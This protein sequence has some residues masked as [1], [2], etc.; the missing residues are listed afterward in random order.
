MAERGLGVDHSTIGRW[1]LRYAPQLNKRIPVAQLCYDVEVARRKLTNK[2]SE[3]AATSRLYSEEEPSWAEDAACVRE[4]TFRGRSWQGIVDDL[5]ADTSALEGAGIP[6]YLQ[7][8]LGPDYLDSQRRLFRLIVHSSVRE[9]AERVLRQEVDAV[10]AGA[11]LETHFE[12]VTDDELMAVVP[13]GLP[14]LAL[15]PWEQEVARR[16]LRSTNGR[17]EPSQRFIEL[18]TCESAKDAEF[19]L[20]ALTSAGIQCRLENDRLM[21]PVSDFDRASAVLDTTLTREPGPD[22]T[23]GVR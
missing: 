15:A 20:D 4:I 1:V 2:K 19:A 7:E 22:A 5:A 10:K 13:E 18:C 3:Q 8:I 23:D 9:S 17:T 14:V 21:V 6:Y 11:A 16:G 12:K